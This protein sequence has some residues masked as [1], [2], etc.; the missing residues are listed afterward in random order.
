M[1]RGANLRN[2]VAGP[3]V[4]PGIVQRRFDIDL[5]YDTSVRGARFLLERARHRMRLVRTWVE[6]PGRLAEAALA[7]EMRVRGTRTLPADPT[8]SSPTAGLRV[9]AIRLGYRPCSAVRGRAR[10]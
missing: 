2:I 10:P 9:L 6:H 7:F 8:A 3:Q 4:S 1:L 5:T